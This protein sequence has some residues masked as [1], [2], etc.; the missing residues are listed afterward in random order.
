MSE[1][2][3]FSLFSGFLF[4]KLPEIEAD[5]DTQE[6]SHASVLPDRY[7][8]TR[9]S[10]ELA[11]LGTNEPT[12]YSFETS[13]AQLHVEN[14]QKDLASMNSAGRRRLRCRQD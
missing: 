14:R 11:L 13:D 4:E 9:R 12:A 3:G 10:L 6:S 2:A 1:P 7:D 5:R 8:Y